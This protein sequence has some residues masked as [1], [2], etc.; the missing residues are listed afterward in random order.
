MDDMRRLPR[1]RPHRG[2]LDS[3]RGLGLA[4]DDVRVRPHLQHSIQTTSQQCHTTKTFN[5]R[6]GGEGIGKMCRAL[7]CAHPMRVG[8]G[9]GIGEGTQDGFHTARS[10]SRTM[11]VAAVCV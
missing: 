1:F 5:K 7:F 3:G 2:R 4:H 8:N 6:G 9:V 11:N 10:R